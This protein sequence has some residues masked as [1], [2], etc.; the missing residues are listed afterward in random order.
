MYL[1][2]TSL[3][4]ELMFTLEKTVRNVKESFNREFYKQSFGVTFDKWLVLEQIFKKQGINQRVIAKSIVKEPAT[5]CRMIKALEKEGIILKINDVKNK[6]SSKLYLTHKGYDLSVRIAK[7][8]Q[9]CY[10]KHFEG[11]Y[12]REM[13]LVNEILNRVN[14]RVTTRHLDGEKKKAPKHTPAPTAVAPASQQK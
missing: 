6:R 10:A 7:M 4:E 9:K 14:S 13:N 2:Q 8:Y 12:D 1:T 11:V 3:H 5:V